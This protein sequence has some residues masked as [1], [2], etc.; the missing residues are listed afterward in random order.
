MLNYLLLS[1]PRVLEKIAKSMQLIYQQNN[2][3]NMRISRWAKGIG[4][5]GNLNKQMGGSG[6]PFG[7]LLANVMFFKKVR[8]AL[9][10]H[11]CRL[12]KTGATAISQDTITYFMSVNI[13]ILR[14][15]QRLI[16]SLMIQMWQEMKRC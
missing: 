5:R 2:D 12:P 8:Q 16:C 1:V 6:T 3:L 14:Q 15:F 7:W 10:L 13:P 9:G 4:L 11:Q